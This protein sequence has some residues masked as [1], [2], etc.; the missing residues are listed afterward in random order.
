MGVPLVCLFRN[1]ILVSI[2]A[3]LE[4]GLG[5]HSPRFGAGPLE[6]WLGTHNSRFVAWPLELGLGTRSPCFVGWPLELGLG[7][8]NAR[9]TMINREKFIV[10]SALCFASLAA[11]CWCRVS[12]CLF[13]EMKSFCL[14]K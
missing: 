4:S 14:L 13:L 2:V 3:P 10:V 12:C 5:I 1:P 11:C 6:V 9:S 8:R 7:T